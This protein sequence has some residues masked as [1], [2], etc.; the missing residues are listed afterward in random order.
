MENNE[1]NNISQNKN[2][3]EDV[4]ESER[5]NLLISTEIISKN[6]SIDDFYNFLKQKDSNKGDDLNLWNVVEIQDVIKEFQELQEKNQEIKI[7]ESNNNIIEQANN[8]NNI[9]TQSNNTL[10]SSI[11]LTT[12]TNEN[13]DNNNIKLA[14][15][16]FTLEDEINCQLPDTTEFLNCK[17]L[18]VNIMFPERS[19]DDENYG[20]KFVYTFCIETSPL[21][22]SVRRRQQDFYWLRK[23]LVKFYPGIF[24]PPI[25]DKN[26]SDSSTEIEV[27]KRMTDCKH[28]L[29]EIIKDELLRSSK[30]FFDFMTT[31]KEKEFQIKRKSYDKMEGPKKLVDLHT[32]TGKINLNDSFFKD[33]NR[34]DKAKNN[35]KKNRDLIEKLNKEFKKLILQMSTLKESLHKI[36]DIFTELTNESI[37]FPENKNLS[38][39]FL[40]NRNLMNDWAYSIKRQSTIFDLHIRQYFKYLFLEYGSLKELHENY[41]NSKNDFLKK[42]KSLDDEKEKL[43]IKKE[44]KKWELL[45][46]DANIDSNNK[47]LCFEKML[48]KK[49]KELNEKLKFTCYYGNYFESEFERIRNQM[50][51]NIIQISDKF[52]NEGIKE[53]GEQK[54]MWEKLHNYESLDFTIAKA[55]TIET[56]PNITKTE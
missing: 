29:E 13:V 56:Q 11:K 10:I 42:K 31:E 20:K 16:L 38:K 8:N 4:N 34:L 40:S 55:I 45:P 3:E 32:R 41:E 53:L 7:N 44:I 23:M 54:D 35:I 27:T 43:F 51:E 50:E 12:Q 2:E 5:K 26:L 30:I 36:A 24:I 37:I 33:V 17:N 52:Y 15:N 14:E 18:S 49:T 47:Q 1:E 48:P 9:L 46:E 39:S 22:F 19:K 6:Y 21:K 28:F 25:K